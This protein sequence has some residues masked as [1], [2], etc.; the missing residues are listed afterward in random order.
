MF[1][2]NCGAKPIESQRFCKQCGTNLDLVSDA[3]KEGGDS[4]GQLRVDMESLKKNF[5]ISKWFDDTP[6]VKIKAQHEKHQEMPK[7]KEWLSYTR[8]HSLKNGLISLFSGLGLG[9]V[10][11][12]FGRIAVNEGVLREIDKLANKN[13]HGLEQF[14][15]WAWLFALIPVLKGIGQIIYGIAFAEPMSVLAERF[16]PKQHATPARYLSYQSRP[17]RAAAQRHRTYDQHHRRRPAAR[18]AR[19]AIARTCYRWARNYSGSGRTLLLARIFRR[20]PAR[21]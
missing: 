8:Q 4:L 13:I 5:D 6:S 7:Q 12:Y 3:L 20:R 11:Y 9:A 2:P 19:Y 1:C 18:R 16:A 15:L 14:L 17:R 21:T 10:L